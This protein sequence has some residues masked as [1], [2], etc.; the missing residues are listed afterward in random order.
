LLSRSKRLLSR[1]QTMRF[2]E[3]PHDLHRVAPAGGRRL[4][5]RLRQVHPRTWRPLRE[6][7]ISVWVLL[8]VAARCASSRVAKRKLAA[9]VCSILLRELNSGASITRVGLPVLRSLR[10]GDFTS[11]GVPMPV[12]RMARRGVSRGARIVKVAHI[13]AVEHPS[14][15]Q[16]RGAPREPKRASAAIRGGP[17]ARQSGKDP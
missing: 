11:A 16:L 13:F 14:E 2:A 10:D 4:R 6:T 1:A 17:G 15:R 9:A 3:P 5:L 8:G 12:H 7:M